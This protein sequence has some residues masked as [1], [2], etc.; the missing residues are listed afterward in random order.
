[1]SDT[2]TDI[3]DISG[4][5]KGAVLAALYNASRVQGMGFLQAKS[6]EMTPEEGAEIIARMG[7]YFDYLHGKVLKI[8]LAGDT[9]DPRLYDRDLGQGAAARAI[10]GLRT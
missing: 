10:E 8:D 2:D 9:L 6:G 3:I 5:D 7:L 1:M 4:L